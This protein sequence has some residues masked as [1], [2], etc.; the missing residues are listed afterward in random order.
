MRDFEADLAARR[1]TA[2]AAL[3]HE[4]SLDDRA[5]DEL[6]RVAV[7]VIR[8]LEPRMEVGGGMALRSFV[9]GRMPARRVASRLELPLQ[10]VW[11]AF[12]AVVPVLLGVAP[13]AKPMG[14]R[15]TSPNVV[16]SPELRSWV[17][18]FDQPGANAALSSREA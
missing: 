3:R 12:R 9:L 5:A 6:V 17:G 7:T 2:H 10:R 16:V 8:E 18:L 14:N 11:D 15:R 4:Q 13:Y 1:E